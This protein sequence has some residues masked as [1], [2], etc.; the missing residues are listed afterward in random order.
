MTTTLAMSLVLATMGAAPAAV[1]ATVPT[2]ESAT[3]RVL[4]SVAVTMGPD[5]TT[6]GVGS[7]VVRTDGSVE[8]AETT[9][10][11]YSPRRSWVTSRCGC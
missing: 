9:D 10:E 2:V 6:T 3:E 5:G 11:S 8:D 7:S 4:Q 1:P